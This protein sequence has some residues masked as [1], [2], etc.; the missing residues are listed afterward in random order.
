MLRFALRR[1]VAAVPLVWGV[2]TLVFLLS[3]AAPGRAFHELEGPGAEPGAAAHLRE[4]LGA[5]RPIW[6]RYVAWLRG[7]VT[8]DLG[9]SFSL[10]SPVSGLLRDGVVNSFCLAGIALALQF[11]LGIAVA[12]LACWWT[13]GWLDRVLVAC[14]SC[15]YSVPSFCLGIVLVGIF[16]LHFGWLP[17][18]QMHSIDADRLSTWS[19]WVDGLRHLLLPALTLSLPAAGGIALYLREQIRALATR[20]FLVAARS[21][22]AGR[23]RLLAHA[24]RNALLPL[25]TLLGLSLPGLVGGAA[26]VEVLYAWPGMGRLAYHAVL[27]RDEPLILGCTLVASIAVVLGSLAADL[28]A[29]AVD[30]RVR[31][32]TS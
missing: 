4:L 17:A 6:D 25:V 9:T 10:R 11:L 20:T 8:G 29:A 19:R 7:S 31:E 18:S 27:A 1:L 14:A 2:A 15:L 32:E 3:Q 28:A 24:G 23:G 5:D 16:S 30:P 21:R 13:G 22:G 26:V 12:L